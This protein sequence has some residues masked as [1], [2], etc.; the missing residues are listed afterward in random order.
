MRTYRGLLIATLVMTPWVAKQAHGATVPTCNSQPATYVGTVGADQI[1]QDDHNP[2][3]VG[4]KGN[5]TF[6]APTDDEYWSYPSKKLTACGWAGNDTFYGTFDYI[7]GGGG[8]DVATVAACFT[9]V[10]NVEE[11]HL[12]SC[13]GPDR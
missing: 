4:G 10:R 7:D 3:A 8:Y 6:R 2:V 12:L 13:N 5:D 1:D 9:V 11:V